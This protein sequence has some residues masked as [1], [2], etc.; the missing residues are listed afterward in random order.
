[1]KK[2]AKESMFFM[3]LFFLVPDWVALLQFKLGLINSCSVLILFAFCFS[4]SDLSKIF[5][6]LIY[7][8]ICNF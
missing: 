7:K 1:M 8:T 5:T 2:Q 6:P 4:D 3:I